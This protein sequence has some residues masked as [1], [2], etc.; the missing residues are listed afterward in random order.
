MCGG[1]LACTTAQ[2]AAKPEPS[3]TAVGSVASPVS[4]PPSAPDASAWMA[5]WPKTW[6]DPRVVDTLA[7]DCAFVPKRPPI[8]HDFVRADL[9]SCTI[10]Y[11]QTCDPDACYGLKRACEGQCEKTCTDCG[12]GCTKSCETCKTS[13]RD[14]ACRK[15]CAASCA[16]C[17]QA[18]TTGIDHCATA[19][20][21]KEY[22]DCG[23]KV[24]A[25][26]KANNCA[27]KCA[28]NKRCHDACQKANDYSDACM[29]KCDEAL[30]PGWTACEEKCDARGSGDGGSTHQETRALCWTECYETIPCAPF[31]CAMGGPPN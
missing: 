27:P 25:A 12:S 5:D 1:V 19:D 30:A 18:C 9:L 28:K 24:K 2:P 31:L 8:S 10:G 29:Q 23:K 15:S 21:G 20:C 22:A 7:A 14:D 26:W 11:H 13:C 16:T 3:G 6:E 4:P 17:K